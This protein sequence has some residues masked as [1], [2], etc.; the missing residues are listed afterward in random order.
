MTSDSIDSLI[1]RIEAMSE[2]ERKALDPIAEAL[3][4]YLLREAPPTMLL[5][6]RIIALAC[7]DLMRQWQ[8]Q[9]I[10]GEH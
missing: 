10:E 5:P 8:S 6:N 7:V 3:F 4:H 1:E 2:D 9:E